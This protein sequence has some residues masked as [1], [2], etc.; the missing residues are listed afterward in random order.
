MNTYKITNITNTLSK[1]D[2]RINT[3]IDIDYVDGI[4]KKKISVR[5][6]ETIYL[7]VSHLPLTVQKLRIM[8][9]ITIAEVSVSEIND[10]RVPT[11]KNIP[12]VSLNQKTVNEYVDEDTK[13]T[14]KKKL[15]ITKKEDEL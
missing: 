2:V 11:K 14:N 1:R 15:N 9:L 4:F 7:T 3:T 12:I 6:G 13:K 8:E 5:A 10:V